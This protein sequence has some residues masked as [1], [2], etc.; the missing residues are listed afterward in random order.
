MGRKSDLLVGSSRWNFSSKCVHVSHPRLKI[1]QMINIPSCFK[2]QTGKITNM[3]H[4]L[5][6]YLFSSYSSLYM[7]NPP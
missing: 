5:L 1:V 6:L 7:V 2:V 4:K 3:V